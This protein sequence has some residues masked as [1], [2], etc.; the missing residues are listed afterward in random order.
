VSQQSVGHFLPKLFRIYLDTYS[1]SSSRGPQP[2]RPMKISLSFFN[3]EY[4]EILEE[5]FL[6]NVLFA[7][8]FQKQRVFI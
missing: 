2:S 6:K 3:S 4:A 7:E 1:K 5:G 8:C